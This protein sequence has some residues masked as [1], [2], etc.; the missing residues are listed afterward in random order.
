MHGET[1]RVVLYQKINTA[2]ALVGASF[3]IIVSMLIVMHGMPPEMCEPPSYEPFEIEADM[4][5]V[6][7]K[8]ATYILTTWSYINPGRP[9]NR[10]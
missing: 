8:A 4:W 7:E 3:L 2:H 6:G 5:L 10:F 9:S 1:R